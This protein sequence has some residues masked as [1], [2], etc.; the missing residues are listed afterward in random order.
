MTEPLAGAKWR[1][2]RVFPRHT[3]AT[4]TDDYAFIG[5]PPLA[6]PKDA[7]EARVSCAFT[8]DLPRAE[9]L[10]RSWSRFGLPVTLGG[11]AL[12]EPG[13]E[14]VPGMYLREGYT[15][16]SRGCPNHCWFCAVWQ[17]ED[18]LRELPIRDGWHVL[19]DNLLAC[20][21]DHIHAVF[22]MLKRQP[23]SAV[24]TGG[25]EAALL[26]PWHVDLLTGIRLR[27]LYCAYDTPDD[28]EPLI[29]AGQMLTEAGITLTT[30]KPCCYVLIGYPDDTLDAAE[31]RLRQTLDVG[32]VPF[33]MLWRDDQRKVREQCWRN[34]QRSWCRPAAIFA[35]KCEYQPALF[36][37]VTP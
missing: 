24:F 25:F 3:S 37:D 22:A 9:E 34:L 16:T 26:R 35:P 20:S 27:R 8:W 14:F 6:I 32:F 13:G 18:G 10:V 5:D 21:E 33:A 17:R 2:I 1:V 7:S 29:V 4:P 28:L 31:A 36:A 11:P 12:G 15:I 30:R 19:D 23:K